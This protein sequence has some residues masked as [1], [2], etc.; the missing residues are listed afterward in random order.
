MPVEV[1]AERAAWIG[2]ALE[3][4]AMV[5]AKARYSNSRMTAPP[6]LKVH[7]QAGVEG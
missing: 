2:E 5:V 6:H 3:A 7:S 1:G 4:M